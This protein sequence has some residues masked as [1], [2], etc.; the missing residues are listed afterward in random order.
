[1]KLTDFDFKLPKE[2]IA[3]Y[4]AE[5]RDHSRLLVLSRANG[6]L[7]HRKFYEIIEYLDPGDALV[8]NQTKV[9]PARLFGKNQKNEARSEVF[10]LRNL[11][12]NIW[13]VLI[14]PKKNVPLGSVINFD[15]GRLSCEILEE[16]SSGASLA[17]FNSDGDIFQLLDE[18]GNTP[19]PPY[20]KREADLKD[21]ERYQTVYAKDRG[22]V[23]AP[24]AGL[25]FTPELL[26][27]IEKK[28]ITVVPITLHIGW[29]TFRPIRGLDF[30]EHKM[31][32][33]FLR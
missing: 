2:L 14:K 22:A 4:P 27:R 25:H 11:D 6:K 12:G 1:M 24:T 28:G 23:A 20:I 13:E 17:R 5:K 26:E 30:Q 16:Q 31:G 33:E 7:E 18:V 29:G 9:F 15:Q 3:Q 8:I 19:L 32:E 10:L 21:R